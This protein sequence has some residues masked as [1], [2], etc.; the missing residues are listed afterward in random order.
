MPP[1]APTARVNASTRFGKR[2]GEFERTGD[3]LEREHDECIADEQCDPLIEGAMDGRSV[4][5]NLGVV[6]ARQVVMDERGA[7]QQLDGG[8]RGD[9]KR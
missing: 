9:G 6:E 8:R 7:V 2:S 1:G 3:V 5:T 4:V